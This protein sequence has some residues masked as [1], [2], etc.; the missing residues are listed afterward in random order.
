MFDRCLNQEKVD[1]SL[2][3]QTLKSRREI[4]RSQRGSEWPKGHPISM[5]S[6]TEVWREKPTTRALWGWQASIRMF[7]KW[8]V[9][10]E[11]IQAR[12]GNILSHMDMEKP[13]G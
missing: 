8:G 11:E 3:A 13:K 1:M 7:E 9:G 2:K 5:L 6:G 10:Y 4:Y 12:K